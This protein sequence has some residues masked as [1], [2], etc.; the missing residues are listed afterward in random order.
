MKDGSLYFSLSNCYSTDD[1][2][3]EFA[4]ILGIPSTEKNKLSCGRKILKGKDV[5]IYLDNIDIII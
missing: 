4:E 3:E 2:L 1:F 5:I